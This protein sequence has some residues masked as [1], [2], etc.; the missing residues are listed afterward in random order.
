MKVEIR[1]TS[2]GE[3]LWIDDRWHCTH[4]RLLDGNSTAHILALACR[5]RGFE[6]TYEYITDKEAILS[7]LRARRGPDPD[8]KGEI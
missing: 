6:V 5:E 2:E 3:E 4:P 7:A 8:L 1:R